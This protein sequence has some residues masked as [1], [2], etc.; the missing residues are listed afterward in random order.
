MHFLLF[1]VETIIRICL[2]ISP[3]VQNDLLIGNANG[4]E[5]TLT[6]IGMT[7]TICSQMKLPKIEVVLHKA[8]NC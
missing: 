6:K 3:L 7:C 2:D 1:F 8:F 4:M 5:L